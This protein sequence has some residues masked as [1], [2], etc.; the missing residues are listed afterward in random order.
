MTFT[1]TNRPVPSDAPE[2]LYF[3]SGLLDQFLTSSDP[4]VTDRTGVE[5]K[6]WF[7]IEADTTGLLPAIEDA[8]ERAE[9]AAA[10]AA[11]AS[12]PYPSVAE[13]L[14]ATSGTGAT[15]RFFSVPGT[16][17]TLMT[18]YRNDAGV[19]TEIG[20]APSAKFV[21]FIQALAQT[22]YGLTD[23][24][25][26]VPGMPWAIGGTNGAPSLGVKSN[27]YAWG[28]FDELPGIGKV[29]DYAWCVHDLNLVVLFG[30][31]WSGE[32][33]LYG[34]T[35]AKALAY[36]EGTPGAQDVW[37][38]VNG[39]PYQVTS[40]GNNSDP[41]VSNGSV[42]FVRRDGATSTT[43][44]ALPEPGSIAGFVTRLVHILGY[45]Q[46]L[47]MGATGEA[48]TLQPPT[49]NRLFT[50]KDG[51]RLTDQ[52]ATLTADMVAPFQPLVTK[53]TEVAVVQLAACLNRNRGLSSN[54]AALVSAHGRNGKTIAELS[55]GSLYYSNLITA[56]TAAKAQAVTLGLGYSVPF[57]D[58]IQGEADYASTQ[59]AY[60]ASLLQ[61]QS[62]FDTDIRA[63][64]GQPKPVPILLCQMS[65][66]TN[67][68]VPSSFVP[69]A[70]LQAAL[71]YPDRFT[72]AGPKYWI[73]SNTDGLHLTGDGYT[74]L[75]AMHRPAAA[76][77]ERGSRWLPTHVI[78]AKREGTK[79]TLEF[80]TPC[81]SLTVDTSLVTDPGNWG[82]R[83]TDD[84]NSA[85]VTAVKLVG[86]NRVELTLSAIPTG[87][88]GFVGVADIGIAGQPLGPTTGARS[89]LRDQS[90]AVD[91]YGR[92]VYNWACHQRIAL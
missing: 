68:G 76:A 87:A 51:V 5:R 62:D 54:A 70:Q 89:C 42:S 63:A 14:A 65:S 36:A 73:Q 37:V 53:G 6:T 7:Q 22:A 52:D 34:Q 35:V 92:P 18:L 8:A 72:C 43:S 26:L 85:S 78:S 9:S 83:Y 91:S 39:V 61:L 16:G 79:I 19:A 12:N 28:L 38:L 21:Q 44:Q 27:G 57:V 66:F 1:P 82:L 86:Q 17:D 2:D 64:S 41:L 69:L 74:R 11:A 29:G 58:F 46:S 67:Y 45:G 56:V 31:K 32:I 71:D 24:R 10:A 30:I 80:S 15:N 20:K 90:T 49:A 33:V 59:A 47:S 77:L 4:S 75:G 60:L 50:I 48:L 55:K 40:S 13:G 25:S 88:N 23:P 84:T 81:G 3:N